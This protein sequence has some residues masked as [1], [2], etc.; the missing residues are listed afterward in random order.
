MKHAHVCVR[1]CWLKWHWALTA[2]QGLFCFLILNCFA[3]LKCQICLSSR[4]QQTS[5]FKPFKTK[6]GGEM[7][8]VVRRTVEYWVTTLT[9]APGSKRIKLRVLS[10]QEGLSCLTLYPQ[11]CGSDCQPRP[12]GETRKTCW[13]LNTADHPKEVI[14][15]FNHILHVDVCQHCWDARDIFST[16]LQKTCQFSFNFNDLH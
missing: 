9:V 14:W 4:T 8:Q 11:R 13:I 6:R 2:F 1:A 10:L 15:C 5:L 3:F 16:V 7:Q 12:L